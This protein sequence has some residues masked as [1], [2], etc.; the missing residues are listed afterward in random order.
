[1][2]PQIVELLIFAVIAFFLVNKLFSILGT[3]D[4]NEKPSFF[5]ESFS[6]KDVTQKLT[7]LD[8]INLDQKHLDIIEQSNKQEILEKL[9]IINS[10]LKNFDIA[11]FVNGAISAF[12]LLTSSEAKNNEELLQNMVDKRFKDQFCNL[13]DKYSSQNLVNPTAKIRDLYLFGNN[14]FIKILF[15]TDSNLFR[16]VWTFTKNKNDTTQHWFLSN[17]EIV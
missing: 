3:T 6:M 1:M 14:V 15:S 10:K 17:I 2:S 13:S 9:P 16:E 7:V 4:E 5:G 11:K 8:K 12:S